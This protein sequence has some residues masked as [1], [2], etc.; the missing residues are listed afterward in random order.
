MSK[1][2]V[3]SSEAR[4][5]IKK[6]VNILADAVKV[7]L[8]PKG[9]NVIIES[10]FG[11]TQ[12]TKDGVTV[13]KAVDLEDQI[14]NIGAQMIKDVASKTV[15][16]AGDGPQPLYSKVLTPN[17][18]VQMKD[19]KLG[20]EVC[21]MN[22][23]VQKVIGIYPKGKK[24]IY[25]ATFSNNRVVECSI[26]HLWDITTSYGSHKTMTTSQ[27]IKSKNISV[28][29]KDGSK[30]HRYYTPLTKVDFRSNTKKMILDSFLVGLLLGD[31]SLSGTGSIELSLALNQEYI[32]DKIILP[33]GITFSITRDLKKH[34]LRIKFKRVT[35][36]G[37]T[38][39]D[40][41]SQL[42]L[43]GTKSDTKFIPKAYLYSDY[44][45]RLKL[46][47]GL[48]ETDGTINN[49][50]LIEYS[51]VSEQLCKDVVELMRGLGKQVY[52]RL[53][54]RKE[55]NSYSMTPIYRI[56]ELVGDKYGIKLLSIKKVNRATEMM[57]IKVSN[58]DNLY[59][60]NDY[61]VTHNTTTATVIAQSIV[62]Q[63]FKM[64]A[65]GANPMDL[66]KGIDKAVKIVVESLKKQSQSVSDTSEEIKQVATVSANGD[67]EVGSL[68]AEA[69]SK[70]GKE[71]VITVEE[72]K[73]INTYVDIIEGMQFDRGYISPY[74][75]TNSE[76]MRVE[77]VQ[78]YLLIYDKEIVTMKEVIRILEKVA[79]SGRSLLIICED[80][81][82]EALQSLVHNKM[83]GKL[84]VAVCKVPGFGDNRKDIL[85]DIA[86]LTGGTYITSDRGL[87]I[88]EADT[89]DLGEA[90]TILVTK[91]Q[92]TIV[93]GLGDR[94]DIDVRINQ[95]KAQIASSTND[96][97]K[98]RLQERLSKLAGGVAV[99][100]VGAQTEVE[101]KEK[102]DRVD[103]ALHATKAAIEEGIIPGGGTA[104][105]RALPQLEKYAST[106]H[107]ETIGFDILGIA[108][109]A[110][111]RA[112]VEN[113]GLD[114]GGI[115]S[116]VKKSK[117]HIGYNARDEKH[118]DLVKAGVIDPT[119]VA[120][121]ALENAA[122]VAGMLL[123]TEC[124]ISNYK[125][126]SVQ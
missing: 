74:F 33:I 39:L 19:L 67:T 64:I 106:N 2:I 80:L 7:T 30:T 3:F 5:K 44:S 100:F 124:V 95:I 21:G 102:K 12:M 10:Q 38:M 115:L 27:L 34:Y 93:G 15:D 32:L 26:D 8:G 55:N 28:L 103:D 43:L 20:D 35:N 75:V 53:Q 126:V 83:T 57:C 118:E 98:K 61:I 78:P 68:I 114:S 116:E 6:G 79:V 90:S 37:P 88:E 104:Y 101:M 112:I 49:R 107:D 99:L 82:G 92:T 113:S 91:D 29:Q 11:L 85:Q 121:V 25:K 18:F 16:L 81:Q 52:Y 72:S 84:K 47:E 77:L 89:V 119:K 120:R 108:I 46:L 86:V 71:G 36:N 31:G 56:C 66:K 42:G 48:V 14:E 111:L 70:V 63:G 50:G 54:E 76:K 105:I 73:G 13:A 24:Q 22:N 45:S 60:T 17:G 58:S 65:A 87:K 40:Y 123:T 51:T 59:I 109:Q 96:A 97:D 4:D 110:P 23:T 94:T 9:R 117:G 125:Q 122:S 69:F 1:Q 41:I 62:N